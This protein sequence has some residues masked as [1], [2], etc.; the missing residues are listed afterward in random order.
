MQAL[1]DGGTTPQKFE[2]RFVARVAELT[3]GRFKIN[4]FAAGQIVPAAQAFDAVRGGA[5]EL[6]KTFDG[7]EAGKIT[8]IGVHAGLWTSEDLRVPPEE[9]PVLRRRPANHPVRTVSQ[10]GSPVALS[11]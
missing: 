9:V 10:A 7:Y 3:G 11:M 6:M 5:F 2:E 8:G 4:L 1:W